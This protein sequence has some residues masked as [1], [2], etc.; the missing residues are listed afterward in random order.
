MNP[1]L[2]LMGLYEFDQTVLD[3]MAY[4][5]EW[6][7]DERETFRDNLLMET[8]ELEILYPDVR[9]MQLAI[10]A[11]SKKELPNWEKLYATTVLEYNPI[12]NKDG[13][14]T[15]TRDLTGGT[16]RGTTEAVKESGRR[17][18]SGSTATESSSSNSGSRNES[19]I[20]NT[21]SSSNA[22][23]ES[24]TS[25]QTSDNS[26]HSVW[27]Y[28][29]AGPSE[30]DKTENDGSASG[31]GSTTDTASGSG[32]ETRNDTETTSDVASGS[33]KETRSDTETTSGS[34]DR[35]ENENVEQKQK[36]TTTRLEQGNI[37]VTTTQS[38]IKEERDVDTFNLM[39]YII[40]SFKK[41]FCILVY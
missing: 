6:T 17:D 18:G 24:T 1:T 3:K 36:E 10:G 34:R 16:T 29:G 41:R 21:E 28:N 11:W 9:F 7:E 31:S 19:G 5:S 2:S 40:D 8:V 38:M 26:I 23:S 15:E 30:A 22:K 32:K 4:P 39:D 12:W 20:T 13:T 35:T 27:G 14:V 25:S 33:G 37:G